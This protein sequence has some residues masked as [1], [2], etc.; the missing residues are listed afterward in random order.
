MKAGRCRERNPEPQE[1]RHHQ[2]RHHIHQ[3]R[4]A[5]R[6][7]RFELLHS[8]LQRSQGRC[9]QDMRENLHAKQIGEK[10]GAHG[11]CVGNP[12]GD[13]QHLPCLLPH[14]GNGGRHQPDDDQRDE[15]LKQLVKQCSEGIRAPYG[16]R[17]SQMPQP[18]AQQ[19]GDEHFDDKRK[20]RK[21]HCEFYR[22]GVRAKIIV[23]VRFSKPNLY[24][25]VRFSKL[26]VIPLPAEEQIAE[27][28][29]QIVKNEKVFPN[30]ENVKKK[31]SAFEH[32]FFLTT[33]SLRK[34]KRT[35]MIVNVLSAKC[36]VHK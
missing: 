10:P 3:R 33:A 19:D 22:S 5:D 9:V 30:F 26:L 14:I 25:F 35:T 2:R 23:F 32:F 20:F 11:E 27:V 18:Y 8:R 34:K 6:E 16:P 15:E 13:E 4:N 28:D 7:I 12:D 17:G 36:A 29:Y 24:Y 21:F 1:E 31:I